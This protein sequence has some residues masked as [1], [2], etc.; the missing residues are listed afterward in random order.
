MRFTKN[1][2]VHKD[3]RPV[4]SCE[5]ATRERRLQKVMEFAVVFLRFPIAAVQ[6]KTAAITNVMDF[7]DVFG[8]FRSPGSRMKRRRMDF[9]DVFLRFP[10]GDQK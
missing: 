3:P 1:D 8:D 2:S 4:A 10:V 5:V 9:A 7:V 6:I